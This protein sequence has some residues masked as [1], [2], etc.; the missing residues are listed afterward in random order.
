MQSDLVLERGDHPEGDGVCLLEAVAREAK[1]PHSDNPQCVCPVIAAYG[2][3]LNDIMPDGQ[4]QRLIPFIPRLL[5]SR[6]TRAV[7]QK[8][9]YLAADYA[10]RLFTP[11][12]LDVHGLKKE[13]AALRAL[14]PIT[15]KETAEAAAETAEAVAP[16]WVTE[17][18]AETG[19]KAAAVRAA[20]VA[21]RATEWA[22]RATEWAAEAAAWA[23]R[24]EAEA[25]AARAAAA[26]VWDK[27]IELMEALL[28]VHD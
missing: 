3:I 1:E 13:A 11:L 2:R 24:A 28:N 12:A 22:A 16:A 27:S 19:A 21:A 7:E 5:A 20:A 15:D 9:A 14:T 8:R 4:R 23:A 26:G 10:V 17:A 25:W 18:T 6:S